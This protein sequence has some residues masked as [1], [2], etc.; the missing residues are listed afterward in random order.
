ME[1]A[2]NQQRSIIFFLSKEGDKPSNIVK[3]LKNVFGDKAESPATIYRWIKRIHDG[4]ETLE[5]EERSGR[6]TTIVTEKNINAVRDVVLTDR[7]ATVQVIAKETGISTG[8]VVTILHD[9]LEMSKLSARW[10]PKL[11]EQ[12]QKDERVAAC[13]AL[14]ALQQQYGDE[15][16]TRIVTTDETWIPYFNPETKEQSKQWRRSDEGPPVKAMRTQSL[17]KVM[18]T[19]FWDCEGIILI[20][21]LPKGT[22]IN[23]AYYSNL[24]TGPVRTALKEKRKGKLHMRPLLQQD[25]ARPHTARL[26]MDT[27][28]KLRWELLPHP[29]YSPDLAPSDYHLFGPLKK[30]LRGKHFKSESEVKTAI[31]AWIKAM[32]KS[33]YE[34]GIK[35]LV[36]RWH[37]CIDLY[38]SYVEKY[39]TVVDE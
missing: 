7:R 34:S 6:P 5:D 29:P 28:K 9:W 30:P 11:L 25:N 18:I 21:Y 1:T 15:F 26:T 24:L 13:K 3:R 2:K 20:D 17:G 32:P 39:D 37:K 4:A 33:F 23:A 27:I 8:S 22:T 36:D 14:L 38:G 35:K 19:V 12:K 31:N 10:V 16:W